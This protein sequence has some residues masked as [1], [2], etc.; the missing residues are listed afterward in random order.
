MRCRI[1][2]PNIRNDDS[3]IND[4]TIMLL[5]AG[6]DLVWICYRLCRRSYSEG[7]AC[8]SPAYNVL[9]DSTN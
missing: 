2:A 9:C 4:Y 5:A 3:M 1:S 8:S 6:F 7:K